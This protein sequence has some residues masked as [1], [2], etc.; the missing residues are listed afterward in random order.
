[1]GRAVSA[2]A[3]IRSKNQERVTFLIE[4][5]DRENVLLP[6]VALFEELKVGI[7]AIWMVRHKRT[8]NPYLSVTVETEQASR[9]KIEDYLSK[10]VGI[11][12]VKTQTGAKA[13]IPSSPCDAE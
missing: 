3:H 7:E 4:A 9:R 2:K 13:L 10:I 12:S 6:V 1:M 8:G 11:L 5:K